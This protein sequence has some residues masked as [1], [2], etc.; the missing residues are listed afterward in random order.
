MFN[1]AHKASVS[2]QAMTDHAERTSARLNVYQDFLGIPYNESASVPLIPCADGS[3][4]CGTWNLNT[5]SDGTADCCNKREGTF[6]KTSQTSSSSIVATGSS[7]SGVASETI[8]TA[9]A[10]GPMTTTITPANSIQL[11]SS[12]SPTP[13]PTS[14]PT[15]HPL[16]TSVVVGGVVGGI[17]AIVSLGLAFWYFMIR[18][19]L[20]DR[21]QIQ[22]LEP[23]TESKRIRWQKPGELHADSYRG[24]ELEA[25]ER[26]ELEG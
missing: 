10:A 12:N 7:Q 16:Y 5:T 11:S 23:N 24:K 1:Y 20:K 22:A 26:R 13:I 17:G 25:A 3:L 18:R 6:L 2:K 4:C 8:I 21:P 15:P 9:A 19:T 14:T